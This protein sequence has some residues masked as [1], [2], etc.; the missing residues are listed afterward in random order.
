M[1]IWYLKPTPHFI[2]DLTTHLVYIGCCA[3]EIEAAITVRENLW[4][5][6]RLLGIEIRKTTQ[7]LFAGRKPSKFWA[8]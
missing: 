7:A 8:A 3:E 4:M 5:S 1:R 6:K 2:I